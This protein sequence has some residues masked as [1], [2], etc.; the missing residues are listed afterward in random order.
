[1]VSA[2]RR[3]REDENERAFLAGKRDACFESVP[4]ASP[5]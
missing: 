1:M 5:Q 2:E 3:K 4:V